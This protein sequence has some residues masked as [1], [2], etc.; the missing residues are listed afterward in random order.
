MRCL[1]F[2]E[3]AASLA[4]QHKNSNLYISILIE[5]LKDYSKALNY[6]ENLPPKEICDYLELYL[7]ILMD[8]CEMEV[9]RLLS[10]IAFLEGL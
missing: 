1:N 7:T 10:K 4:N 5:D 8:N 3:I 6:I 2:S 9:V